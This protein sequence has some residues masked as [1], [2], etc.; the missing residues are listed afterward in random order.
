MT[1]SAF[2][3]D[4]IAA[5]IAAGYKV[6]VV[7]NAPNDSFLG[8]LGLSA[9][10][11]PVAIVRK[12]APWRDLLA[13]LV[14]CRVFYFS[15]FDIVHSVSPKAGLL[16]MLAARICSVPYRVHTFTGQVWVIHRGPRRWLLK[17]VDMVLA[18][19]TTSVLVDSPSQREYLIAERVVNSHKADALGNGSICGVDGSR[20][21]PDRDARSRIRDELGVPRTAPL[22]LFLGRLNRDKGVLDLANAFVQIAE[23]FPDAWLL[24]VG[25]DEGGMIRE[26]SDIC[27]KARERVSFVDYTNSPEHYLASADIF[28][29]ASYREGFGMV[30]LEA[31][32]SGVPS[33]ASR[34]Y[35]ISD[36]LVDGVTGLLHP[37]GDVD[38][39]VRLISTLLSDTDLRLEM[40]KRARERALAEFSKEE[41]SQR[42]LSFYEKIVS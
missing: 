2:L 23:R 14:L 20:F 13:L 38:S 21:Q 3:K 10:F 4:H 24:L 33:V 36:A 42:L 35:G 34:I 15:R 31:A 11:H 25:P 12:I 18:A 1:V 7:A 37:P 39:M 22:L 41:S 32:A 40:G 17:R 27:F 26:V 16:A 6:S 19:L 28:C 8:E 9:E 30:I 5:A 29:L